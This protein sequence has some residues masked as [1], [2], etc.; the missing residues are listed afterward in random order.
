M[1]IV[2]IILAAGSSSRM[3]RPKQVLP[4]GGKSLVRWSAE[5]ATGSRAATTIVVTGAAGDAVA[6]E[7]AGLPVQIVHNPDYAEGMSTSLR[8]GLRAAPTDAEA[9]VV[10]LAD[11]PFVDATVVDGLIGLYEQRPAPIVRPRYDGQ[12]GNPVLWDRALFDELLAQTGDQGGRSVLQ[13]HVSEIIWLDLP[14]A[15]V[16]LDVDTPEAY[17]SL[18]ASESPPSPAPSQPHPHDDA[19]RYCQSC[20]TPLE[21]RPV[22]FDNN[23]PHPTCPA[24][25]F[26][27]WSDPKV[28]VLAVIPWEGGILLGRRTQNP[29]KG[30]W[31]FPSGFVDR[32]EPVEEALTREVQEETGLIVD[33]I[34]LVG[35]YS[36]RGNPVIVLAYAVEPRAGAL[37]GEDDL[38][39]L[40][41][42]PSERLPEMAFAHDERIV[43]DWLAFRSRS[44]RRS[45]RAGPA[46]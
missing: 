43:Q 5:A 9:V 19:L 42:F 1:S 25:G 35:V 2:A 28:A 7:L 20:A 17:A 8:A 24:C 4:L 32:G 40:R 37:V 39:D 38:V 23:R 16:Q 12:P 18:T 13:R 27:V 15:R 30:K 29:G 34:G 22:R 11:Q 44:T 36:A 26:I 41:G 6:G 31:S 21:T 33:V 10:L 45:E 3:G 14:D 46:R